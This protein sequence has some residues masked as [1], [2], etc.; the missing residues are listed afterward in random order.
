VLARLLVKQ[1][2]MCKCFC[3]CKYSPVLYYR[4]KCKCSRVV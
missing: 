2:R 4:H 1:F 3:K